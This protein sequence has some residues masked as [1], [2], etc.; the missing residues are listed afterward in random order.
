LEKTE[1]VYL[2]GKIK[3]FGKSTTEYIFSYTEIEVINKYLEKLQ[4]LKEQGFGELSLSVS[5]GKI[6]LCKL[7]QTFK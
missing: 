3:L 4:K 1:K 2:T 6:N 5:D 7:Y